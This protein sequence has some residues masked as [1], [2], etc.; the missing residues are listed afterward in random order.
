M[1]NYEKFQQLI[2]QGTVVKYDECSK[3]EYYVSKTGKLYSVNKETHKIGRPKKTINK[4]NYEFVYMRS[5]KK[6]ERVHRIVA[7]AFVENTLPEDNDCVDHINGI[8]NDNRAENLQWVSRSENSRLANETVQHANSKRKFRDNFHYHGSFLY[9]DDLVNK[10][11]GVKDEQ[12]EFLR[13]QEEAY[14]GYT[15]NPEYEYLNNEEVED[16]LEEQDEYKELYNKYYGK[17]D[18]NINSLQ[19]LAKEREEENKYKDH[20]NG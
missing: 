10:F 19:Y 20:Y 6:Q 4:F 8:K 12:L 15:D 18:M 14:D 3:K 17:G 7:K 11:R 9:E 1:T 16:I 13:Q 5:T 2:K